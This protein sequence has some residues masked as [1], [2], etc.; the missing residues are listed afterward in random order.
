MVTGMVR[1]FPCGEKNKFTV[2]CSRH[3]LAIVGAYFMEAVFILTQGC[4]R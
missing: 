3:E 2:Y 4:I 1:W